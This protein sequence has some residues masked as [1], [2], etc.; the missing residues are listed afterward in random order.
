MR[1]P[2]LYR[3]AVLLAAGSLIIVASGSLVTTNATL[4]EPAKGLNFLSTGHRHGAMGLGAITL[5]FLV[6][7]SLTQKRLAR[8][9]WLLSAGIVIEGL[10][11]TATVTPGEPHLMSALHATLAH[12]VTGGLVVFA[13]MLS[14][15]W[16]R[17]PEYVRDY[18]WP[19]MRSLAI[20]VP[21]LVLVQVALGAAF[22][23]QV[24]GLLPHVVG[25][26]VVSLLILMLAAFVLHQFPEHTTLRPAARTLMVITFVQVF[27]GIA[28]FTVRSL[29]TQETAATLIIAAAHVSTGAL[30]LSAS[31]VL[32]ALIRRN[33]QPKA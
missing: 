22:R 15:V 13:L 30:T 33:V 21:L 16:E 11:G 20:A 28:A 32:G 1:N 8:F 6:W 4:A 2:W 31:M 23:Q 7:I 9:G 26:M 18:G 3:T 24:L 10:L 5:A 14:P 12:V 19:S 27:L 17:G 25:A 29:R